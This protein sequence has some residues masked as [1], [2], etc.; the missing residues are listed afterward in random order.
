M[1]VA[2]TLSMHFMRSVTQ[3]C[4]PLPIYCDL[5]MTTCGRILAKLKYRT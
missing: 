3:M 4:Y 5:V 1:E 2:L